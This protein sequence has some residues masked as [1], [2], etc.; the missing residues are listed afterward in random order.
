MGNSKKNKADKS[1]D[2]SEE[3]PSESDASMVESF[4]Q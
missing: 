4:K 1:L 3:N 2:F